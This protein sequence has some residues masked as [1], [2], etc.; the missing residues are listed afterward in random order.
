MLED[1]DIKYIDYRTIGINNLVLLNKYLG[2]FIMNNYVYIYKSNTVGLRSI[3]GNAFA[4]T[5]NLTYTT[6]INGSHGENRIRLWFDH[7]NKNIISYPHVTFGTV[8]K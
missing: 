1:M 2:P 7:S 3:C 6:I 8:R 5:H 4:W